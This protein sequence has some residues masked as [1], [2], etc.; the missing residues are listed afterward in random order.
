MRMIIN[1]VTFVWASIFIGAVGVAAASLLFKK[2]IR[3]KD[4]IEREV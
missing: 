1:D 4:D 3:T 2:V